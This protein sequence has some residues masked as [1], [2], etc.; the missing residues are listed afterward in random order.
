MSNLIEY[1]KSELELIGYDEKCDGIDL[2]MKNNILE[3]MEVFSKQ[4]HSGFSGR[5]CIDVFSSLAR[6]EPLKPV[7]GT[8]DEW[9]NVAELSDGV[10]MFQNKRHYAV[11]KDS[12]NGKPY[13][14]DAIVWD[15]DGNTFTGTIEGISSSQYI[16]LPFIPKTFYIKINE[17]REIINHDDLN[18]VFNYYEKRDI[19]EK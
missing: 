4:G 18:D 6:F 19:T 11:F 2:L 5:Y 13:F 10:P 16:K 3:L 15:Q 9:T 17:N 7:M 14:L 8:D 12:E 1:A